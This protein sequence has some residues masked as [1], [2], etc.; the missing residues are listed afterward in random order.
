MQSQDSKSAAGWF[1][2]D[3]PLSQALPRFEE[4]AGQAEMAAAVETAL[5]EG[6][7]LL[8]EAGTGTGKTLAYLL[9]VLL[10]GLK[11]VVSTG[12]KTLQDQILKKDL[13]ALVP[14]LPEPV[15]A[16]GLKG[17][18]NY[19]CLR[20][21]KEAEEESADRLGTEAAHLAGWGRATATGDRAELE[22]LP[23][24]SPLWE[25]VNVP[26]DA[27][28]GGKCPDF[29]DCFLTR[30]RREAAAADLVIVNHH[31]YLADL[32]VRESGYGA[33][34][35]PH[36]AV[37]FDEAHG[38]EDAATDYFGFAA[39]PRRF[40]ELI[41][42][43]THFL[44]AA[45]LSSAP[46]N[47]LL[48]GLADASRSFFSLLASEGHPLRLTP[49]V[50]PVET[51][52][53]GGELAALTRNLVSMIGRPEGAR[54][55]AE[56]LARRGERLAKD[57]ASLVLAE[58]PSYVFWIDRKGR[59]ALR[60]SPVDVSSILGERIFSGDRAVILTSAT[61]A[62]AGRM[63]H[64]R[65]RLGIGAAEE[66]VIA[67]PFDYPRQA[68]LYV[69]VDLPDPRELDFAERAA[70]EILAILE[71][72]RGR[73]LV[74]FTS[75]QNLADIGNRIAGRVRFPLLRQGEQPRET[76]LARFRKEVDSV[77]LATGSFWEGVDVPGEALSCVIV[78]RLPFDS[79]G[80]P[81][82]AARIDRIREGGEDPF[83]AYQ[84]PQAVIALRQGLGRLI[85]STEDRGVLV[86]LDRRLA[87]KS[88][89][90]IFRKALPPCPFT[91]RIEDVEEFFGESAPLL[92]SPRTRG[93]GR[94]GV[95]G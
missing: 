41:R 65:A 90:R 28:L 92:P 91:T 8:A 54:D 4:R 85:R 66:V 77:L 17:K 21:F 32:A 3:G 74:L 56:S 31:L 57:L 1:S 46:A 68:L 47:R 5:R 48:I 64:L 26:G 69:P 63:D 16:A 61:L 80:D 73:A 62:V 83:L 11:T 6:R 49:A 33:V 45:R 27:C 25:R 42:D 35:P 55:E 78:D 10:S 43:A 19:L 39:T 81:V 75:H 58:D 9:P 86:V 7:I 88:Y 67:S 15:R 20:R 34:I 79:P 94:R 84:V 53:R 93:E 23:D 89:G 71:R 60:A 59:P 14:L 76:L 13:P 72:S 51:R 87:T 22:D 95:N 37:V 2:P 50:V 38:L 30:A 70:E 29:D 40:E 12:T 82:L 18:A 44:S 52:T 24:P 36:E